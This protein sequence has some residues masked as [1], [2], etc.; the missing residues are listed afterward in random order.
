M[1]AMDI[2]ERFLSTFAFVLLNGSENTK[3][4]VFGSIQ[5]GKITFLCIV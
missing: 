5:L 2:L 4:T 1:S 3:Y